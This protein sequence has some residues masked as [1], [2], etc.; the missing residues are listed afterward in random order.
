M[1]TATDRPRAGEELGR[2]LRSYAFGLAIE[3][4]FAAP[5]L[6]DGA[7]PPRGVPATRLGLAP[8]DAIDM[9]WRPAAPERLLEEELGGR[10]K[11][12]RTIDHDEQ[13]GYRLYARHFGLALIAPGG[14]DVLCAPPGVA[15]WRWQRFLVGRVLP[16]AA[17]VSG[18]EVIHASA[19]RIGDRAVALM[20]AT[21]G[22]KTSL[23]LRL[24]LRG[25]GF[26]TDDVLALELRDGGLI[27]HPGA[28]TIAIRPGEKAA[29]G[30][31]DLRRLGRVLG[32][33]GKTYVA[34]D[35]EHVPLPLGAVYV[36]TP[37]CGVGAEIEPG[38]VD[39]RT[40][41]GGSFVSSVTGPARLTR[42]L[43]VCAAMA[44]GVPLFRAYVDP[45]S[46]SAALA[47][48]IHEH[49]TGVAG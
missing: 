24:V 3:S 25:A 11:P 17:L 8:R 44:A 7:R 22:G 15:A 12:A 1:A 19:V 43:E 49:A 13:A 36:L 37:R 5:G 10:G 39:A 33:S 27:A 48:A 34:V 29:L 42:L 6:P 35:R 14:G 32:T 9:R 20:G 38:G 23:A 21:G 4:T 2:T 26:F 47:G 16:W 41:L 31:R 40:L 18:H 30:R 28:S 46:G 45:E